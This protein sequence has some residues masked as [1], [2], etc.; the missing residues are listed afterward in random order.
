MN[1]CCDFE[2]ARPARSH[3]IA[4]RFTVKSRNAESVSVAGTFNRWQP[5]AGRLHR[6]DDACWILETGLL[7]GRYE[8]QWVVDGVWMADPNSVENVPNPYGGRNSVLRVVASVLERSSCPSG[9]SAE[10]RPI[11]MECQRILSMKKPHNV[12]RPPHAL[13][14]KAVEPTIP[15]K[16]KKRDNVFSQSKDIREDHGTRQMKTA[17]NP[18][19]L[20]H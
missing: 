8:Y 18:R 4:I 11:K 15:A 3:L 17:S 1:H 14:P 6:V 5:G 7:P 20:P 16:P 10:P 13:Q 19:T 9:I 12:P 2:S